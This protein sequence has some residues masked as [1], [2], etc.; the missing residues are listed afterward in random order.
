MP[1]NRLSPLTTPCSL[2]VLLSNQGSLPPPALPGFCGST[3]PSATLSARLPL[4]GF[5]L[6]RAHRR[7]GF[8][9]CY[10]PHL[11]CVLPLLPQRNRPMLAPLTSRPVAAFP[12]GRVGR[13]PHCAFRGLLDVHSRCGP[14]GRRSRPRRPL[15]R[16][17]SGHVVTSTTRSD[18]YRL[19]RQLPGEGFA[20]A[21]GWRHFTALPPTY[22]PINIL[23]RDPETRS[24]P[25]L[26]RKRRLTANASLRMARPPQSPGPSQYIPRRGIAIPCS[27]SV[28]STLGR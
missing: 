21:R 19:E 27:R 11:P 6:A 9:C 14:H 3:S 15:H 18:R 4:A 5:R 16:S 7:R 12:I 13:L 26:T 20:P 23:V 28:L 22:A 10:H 2:S 1:K 8:P 25:S 17:A 24:R